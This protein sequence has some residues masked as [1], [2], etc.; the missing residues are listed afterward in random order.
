MDY[1]FDNLNGEFLELESPRVD[2]RNSHGTG[3]T[4]SSAITAFLAKGMDLSAAVR[5]A[6]SYINGA[7]QGGAE[8]KIGNG[9]GPV[10]HFHNWWNV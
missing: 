7:L 9:H 8:M 1:L 5:E 3:C 6:K 4:V 2:T 10:H